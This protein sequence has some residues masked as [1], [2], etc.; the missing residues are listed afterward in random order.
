MDHEELL[1]LI[2]DDEFGV[3]SI[4]PKVAANIS[5]ED[6]LI[7]AFE[8]I[9]DFLRQTNR[10]PTA[11]I[12]DMIEF[13]L[14]S[15][16]NNI[17]EDKSKVEILKKYDE[18]SLLQNIKIIKTLDDVFADDD[19][20][21][22]IEDENSIFKIQHVA[23]EIAVPDYIAKRKPCNEFKKFEHLF[24][25]C[26]SD[27]A[28]GK[29]KILPFSNEIR[30]GLFFIL[31][32]VLLYVSKVERQEFV[33]GRL[34]ARLHCIYENGTES[35]IL[36]RSLAAE[37]YNDGRLVTEHEDK[38]LDGFNIAEKTENIGYIYV[39]RSLS[40]RDEIRSIQNLYKIGFSRMPVED[41]IKNAES[42]PTFLFAP[43]APVI[44]YR[45]YDMNSQKLESL[46][47]NIF[48]EVCLN[49]DLFDKDGK[50]YLPREWFIAPL[51][52]IEQAIQ[53][54]LDQP[55]YESS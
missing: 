26:Q 1:K 33:N 15:R 41:R 23:K 36:M 7:A 28:S 48:G 10:Q 9:N 32:G 40:E 6:R 44:S 51:E 47:H 35:D 18:F 12:E 27:L 5:A 25:E 19:L 31:K 45:C 20:G 46:L 24:N 3:L 30:K 22:F 2:E 39:V 13:G 14:Y 43:V 38:L 21:L 4:K 16:L 54:L 29:R 34:N 49:V 53:L 50:R 11:N 52:T 37:L 42:E 55:I 8:E 17:K